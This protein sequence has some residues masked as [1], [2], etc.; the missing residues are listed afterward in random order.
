MSEQ[1]KKIRRM[2]RLL[3]YI[4]DVNSVLGMIHDIPILKDI[5]KKIREEIEK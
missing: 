4:H 1:E 3:A 2:R 5:N